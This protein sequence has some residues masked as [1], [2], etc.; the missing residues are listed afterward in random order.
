MYFCHYFFML[1]FILMGCGK[2]LSVWMMVVFLRVNAVK[3][4]S[5]SSSGDEVYV[6]MH[7]ILRRRH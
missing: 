7:R 5:H 4:D 1:T 3:L 6:F 2:G